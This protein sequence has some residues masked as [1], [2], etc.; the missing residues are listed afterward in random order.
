MKAAFD[1]LKNSWDPVCSEAA[2]AV[3]HCMTEHQ[4]V[5]SLDEFTRIP[6]MTFTN[7]F[8]SRK[9]YVF[10]GKKQLGQFFLTGQ[11]GEVSLNLGTL[12]VGDKLVLM[13]GADERDI[14]HILELV[15][16]FERKNK[17]ILAEG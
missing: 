13:G 9:S 2:N 5:A 7:V 10:D 6:T 8:S 3:A 17:E 12:T 11:T 1:Q 15:Q 4:F 14:G 16:L